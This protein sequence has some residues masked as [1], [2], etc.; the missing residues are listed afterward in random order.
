M[1]GTVCA[2]AS[3][4]RLP[5]SRQ[6]RNLL[7]TNGIIFRTSGEVPIGIQLMAMLLRGVRHTLPRPCPGR[8]LCNKDRRLVCTVS[9]NKTQ[10][11]KGSAAR[12]IH[13]APTN[14]A[15][16]NQ[17]SCLMV[18]DRHK[19]DDRQGFMR[20]QMVKVNLRDEG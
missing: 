13:C 16:D 12:V 14:I 8:Y 1:R 15:S 17:E 7:Q 20:C 19:S 5:L 11:A 18:S 6:M 4:P 9:R 3:R 10:P 2:S